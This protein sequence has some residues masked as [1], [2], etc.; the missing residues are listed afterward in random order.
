MRSAPTGASA[1]RVD[2]R[3]NRYVARAL[4]AAM[5]ALPL[6]ASEVA[7]APR[8]LVLEIDG[9][10]GPAVADYVVRELRGIGQSDTRL[11]ILRM[12]TPGGRRARAPTS[13]MRARSPPWLRAPTSAPP[14]RSKWDGCRA[15]RAERRN[16]RTGK[17]VRRRGA[18]I[19]RAP[20][21][22][23]RTPRPARR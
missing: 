23:R 11:V 2:A 8:A 1:R 13:P 9:A 12:N 14:P 5:V 20:P 10:I 15:S 19:R 18:R 3:L 16:S 22:S 17:K 7:A 6:P 4:F 21:P